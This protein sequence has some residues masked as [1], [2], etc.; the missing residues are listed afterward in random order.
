MQ[1]VTHKGRISEM[2]VV[3]WQGKINGAQAIISPIFAPKDNKKTGVGVVSVPH[4]L[5]N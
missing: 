3:I 5:E 4:L 2:W 1:I